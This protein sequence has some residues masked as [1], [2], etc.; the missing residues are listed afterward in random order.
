[1]ADNNNFNELLIHTLKQIIKIPER[2]QPCLL[3]NQTFSG[4]TAKISP[5]ISPATTHLLLKH[6][7]STDSHPKALALATP[8]SHVPSAHQADP[9]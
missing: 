1:M 7:T 6:R 9:R 5:R 8:S 4:F 2:R 3:N